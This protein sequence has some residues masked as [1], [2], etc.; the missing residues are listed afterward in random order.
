MPQQTFSEKAMRHTVSTTTILG[1]DALANARAQQ[2]GRLWCCRKIRK[3]VTNSTCKERLER[4][5]REC[6]IPAVLP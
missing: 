3:N 5:C 6:S 1:Q 4:P 2:K